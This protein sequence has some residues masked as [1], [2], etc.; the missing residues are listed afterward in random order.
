[1]KCS[2][3]TGS[4]VCYFQNLLMIVGIESRSIKGI[5]WCIFAK[6]FIQIKK[7]GTQKN[8]KTNHY[9]LLKRHPLV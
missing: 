1:M 7:N 3:G 8:T 2:D 5:H 6:Q 9:I 4:Q